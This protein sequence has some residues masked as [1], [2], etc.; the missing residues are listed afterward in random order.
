MKNRTFKAAVALSLVLLLAGLAS[1]PNRSFA[2]S[3]K[4][5]PKRT[6]AIVYDNSGSMFQGDGKTWCQAQY[7][8]EVFASMMNQGDKLMIYPMWGITIGN[9]GGTEYS[10]QENKP[11]IITD[12]KKQIESIRNIYT[13]FSTG[14]AYTPIE[15]IDAAV[16]GLKKEDGEKWLIVLTDGD[17]F[18][19]NPT[20][21]NPYELNQNQTKKALE[22]RFREDIKY[23]NVMYLGIGTGIQAPQIQS[24]NNFLYEARTAAPANVPSVLTEMCNI[25]FGRDA[26]P[27]KYYSANS[28]NFDI[29]LSKLYVFIQGENIS[30]V[31]L[32]GNG[33]TLKSSKSFEPHYGT[34]GGRK[35]NANYI[36]IPDETLQGTIAVYE[37]VPAGTYSCDYSGKMSSIAYYYEPDVDVALKLLDA[38]GREITSADEVGPGDYQLV[39]YLTDLNGNPVESELLG[40]T[41]FQIDYQLNGKDYSE[42]ASKS[43]SFPLHIG[44]GD[45]FKVPHAQAEILSGYKIE[46]SGDDLGFLG[47]GIKPQKVNV[48]EFKVEVTYPKEQYDADDIDGIYPVAF[49]KDGVKLTGAELDNVRFEASATNGLICECKRT[50][51]GYEIHLKAPADKDAIQIGKGTIHAKGTYSS[52]TEEPISAEGEVPFEILDVSS[53]LTMSFEGN[54]MY[55]AIMDLPK[56]NGFYVN[57]YYD[58]QPLTE[59]QMSQIQFSI[60]AED[61][62]LKY[63]RDPGESRYHVISDPEAEQHK[64]F[65]TMKATAS[66]IRDRMG[67]E[68]TAE[69]KQ[70][71]ELGTIPGWLRLL[72]ILGAILLLIALIVFILTRPA[73]PK[74]IKVVNSRV[75]IDGEIQR[76]NVGQEYD[77]SGNKRNFGVSALIGPGK[78]GFRVRL[79]PAKGSYVITPSKNRKAMVIADSVSKRGY[80]TDL[81]LNRQFALNEKKKLESIV[82][83]K[84]NFNLTKNFSYSGTKMV[85]GV[86]VD[87]TVTGDLRF[88]NK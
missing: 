28:V 47:R 54:N 26:L 32:S 66:G 1:L 85:N 5:V 6:I 23:S 24:P 15:S 69:K 71:V 25:I 33:Q 37:N 13:P 4:N 50:N 20:G 79:V 58:G 43:G 3:G 77:K 88:G 82:P 53:E 83:A 35:I 36:S 45:E 76:I 68:L 65:H 39:Y 10:F 59:E 55:Y 21:L 84:G 30:S 87:Y 46:K 72:I 16:E 19:E 86:S 42:K 62:T 40:R 12:D 75:V 8:M 44:V 51:D 48:R 61:M 73:L 74:R 67:H 63:E 78:E 27:G 7:A 14:N 41:D 49:Y 22:D 9:N 34:L 80:V 2:M 52:D 18:W 11:L 31:K 17:K 81:M 70:I 57:L 38:S 60:D 64:G 56:D 29:P